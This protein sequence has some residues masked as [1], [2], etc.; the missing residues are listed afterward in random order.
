MMR[1]GEVDDSDEDHCSK[2]GPTIGARGGRGAH[3]N[4]AKLLI[5]RSNLEPYG[6]KI[7]AV[8][9]IANGLPRPGLQEFPKN[10]VISAWPF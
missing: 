6:P 2:I 7:P 1:A 3:Q 8:Q 9:Q 5:G 4:M 10:L